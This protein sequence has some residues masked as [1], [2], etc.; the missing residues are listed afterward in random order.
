[1][2]MVKILIKSIAIILTV[3]LVRETSAKVLPMPIKY[4]YNKANSVL[5]AAIINR[6]EVKLGTSEVTLLIIK[7]LKKKY[8]KGS[9]LKIN[10]PTVSYA[11]FPKLNAGDVELLFINEKNGKP[12][13]EA[14]VSAT[15]FTG[16]PDSTINCGAAILCNFKT[17]EEIEDYL[18]DKELINK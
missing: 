18:N 1:M 15:G 2:V 10:V 17:F 3:I 6:N 11:E 14:H 13:I 8:N 9:Q 5:V 4:F 7:D 16:N 12:A